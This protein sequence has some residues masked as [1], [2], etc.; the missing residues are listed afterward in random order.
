[1]RVDVAV[2]GGGVSG[3]SAAWAL[4][5]RGYEV[6]VLERQVRAGG[7]AIS[8]R[9][10]GFLM[11][12]GPSSVNAA[13]PAAGAVSTA[14][15][16]DSAWC[17]LG[18]GVRYR[19]LVG[20]AGLHRIGAHPLGFLCSGYLSPGARLRMLG[21]GLVP[22]GV[23]GAEET[24]EAFWTRRFGP[25]FAAR[26]IDPLVGGLFA[27]RADR[28]SMPA[29]FPALVEME[30]QYGS[31]TATLLRRGHG[32]G[33]GHKP[34]PGRR[35]Y[36]WR[37]GIGALPAALAAALG[38]ALRTGAVARRVARRGDGYRIDLGAGGT[39][40]ARAVIVATQPHVAAG[41]LDGL[42]PAAAEA[43]AALDAPPLAVVFLGYQRARVAHP[44]DG[45]GYLA[46]RGAGRALSGALFCSTMFPGRAP[47]GH[48]AL[49]GYLGG[50]RA[51]ELALRPARELVVLARAEFGDLLGA[52]GAP[53]VTRVRQWPRGLP[54]YT[55]GHGARVAALR[56]AEARVPGLFVTGNYLQGI[57]L[58]ACV[59]QA[60]AV[61]ARAEA[62]LEGTRARSTHA[63]EWVGRANS[64]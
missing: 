37:E 35:L 38:P 4:Q 51:P 30:R 57:S 12:H 45:L 23:A 46:P 36:S 20:A 16:L 44:L 3:L 17:E 64:A 50:A 42:D 61:A 19:Y 62:Y 1:M 55:I 54:Q 53:V 14:L 47:V 24:V 7:N 28:L 9:I 60:H 49:A 11:E 33:R 6:A 5:R 63:H 43:A 26:V 29:V 27:G 13:A 59:D 25:E 39:L 21:E 18:A 10:G 52:R 41:L 15:G 48:V 34:M 22:R 58:G 32:W 31:I 56:G 8:E 2:I 40:A